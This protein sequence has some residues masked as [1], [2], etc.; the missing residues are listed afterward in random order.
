MC[1]FDALYSVHLLRY[2]HGISC[3]VLLCLEY[4][5]FPKNSCNQLILD[6]SASLVLQQ[7]PWC[8]LIYP[9]C[10]IC[11]QSAGTYAKYGTIRLKS[12]A[13]FLLVCK[14]LRVYTQM[15]LVFIGKMNLGPVSVSDKTSYCKISWSLETPT[16]V[17]SVIVSLWNLTG[18]DTFTIR[19]FIGYWNGALG[20][21][22]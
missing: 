17:V 22:Q 11:E 21:K 7:S 20:L 3:A 10:G 13:K 2:T 8:Q 18:F 19:R 6:S 4:E 14:C 12:V 15:S 1:R 9:A 5:L 16:L